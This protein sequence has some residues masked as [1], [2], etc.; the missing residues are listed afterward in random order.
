MTEDVSDDATRFDLPFGAA[1]PRLVNPELGIQRIVARGD[2]HSYSMD[3]TVLD[4]P[5]HRLVRA[6]VLLAHRVFDGEGEW[7]LSAPDW[8][9]LLPVEK[10]EPFGEGDLPESFAQLIRPFRRTA[11]LAPVA[12]CEAKRVEYLVRGEGGVVLATLRDEQVTVKRSGLTTARYREVTLLPTDELTPEQRSWVEDAIMQVGGAQTTGFPSFV[13]RLGAPATGRSDLPTLRGWHRDDTLEEFVS[14]LMSMHLHGI[15]EADLVLRAGGGDDTREV[16]RELVRLQRDLRG[17]YPVLDATWRRELEDDLAAV[18]ETEDGASVEVQLG[19]RYLLVLEKLVTAVRGPRLG[20][21][22]RRCA[23]E[24]MAEELEAAVVTLRSRFEGL[25]VDSPDE[26]WRGALTSARNVAVLARTCRHLWGRKAR[27][28]SRR[29]ERIAA[30]LVQ[31]VVMPS[32]L[33][34]DELSTMS[35]REAFDRGRVFERAHLVQAVA[36]EDLLEEW[37]RHERRLKVPTA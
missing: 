22:A 16:R 19:E 37:P 11:A 7:Y 6:G 25:E 13:S 3:V 4:A 36:R 1:A 26:A 20:S 12:S 10:V 27:G 14:G 32:D 24:V 18:L 33:S 2:S 21:V 15:V 35:L 23:G 30:R 5:D 31:C 17:L 8:A 34:D 29:A 28:L 9:P